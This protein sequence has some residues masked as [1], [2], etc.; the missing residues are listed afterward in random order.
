[1]A[2]R[3]TL[4]K[5]KETLKIMKYLIVIFIFVFLVEFGYLLYSKFI[6]KGKNIY[7]DGINSIVNL[8][9]GFA[10]VGS[11]NNNDNYYER[12]KFTIYNDKKDKVIEK[13]YNKGYNS[14]FFDLCEVNDGYI[15]VG[16]L[17]KNK[18]E[19]NKSIREALV[20]KYDKDGKLLFE[21]NFKFLNNTKFTSITKTNDGFI[22][23]GQSVYSNDVIGNAENGGAIVVKYDKHG[24]VQWS[25]SF[26][27]KKSA[28]F[29]DL[30]IFNDELYVV[31]K[32]KDNTGII[33]KYNLDGNFISS[34]TYS[35]LDL[36]GFSSIAELNGNIFVSSSK[37]DNAI[38]V[39]YNNNLN[40]LDEVLYNGK[41]KE[42]YNKILKINDNNILVIGSQ[43]FKKK[44]SNDISDYYYK[45]IISKYNENLDE[46]AVEIYDEQDDVYF[47]DIIP[48]EED[49]LVGGYS[50]YDDGNYYS[51]FVKYSD[52]L[53]IL[54]S[55]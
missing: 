2:R 25:E 47:N 44:S 34:D 20:V 6:D 41:Y 40:L 51:K 48:F 11:N 35:G 54:E 39:K 10:S 46:I 7:F 32:N 30:I 15:V 5:K 17:E 42:R 31:G 19:H 23:S 29:N 9:N 24:K 45:G 28:C 37:D 49:Y 22:V 52:A 12:A 13:I 27:N 38:V 50:S 36:I 21:K 33:C 3:K 16:S 1:M 43:G 18:E 55:E 26:G 4:K 8:E 53:K 14:A